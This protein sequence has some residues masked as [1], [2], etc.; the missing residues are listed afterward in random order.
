MKLLRYFLM[1]TCLLFSTSCIGKTAKASNNSVPN[2]N[3]KNKQKIN[4]MKKTLIIF[5]S[6]PGE[7]YGV[8]NIK[9]G[10][11]KI[12]ADDIMGMIEADEFEVVAK[13]SYDMP[14]EK[15]TEVAKEE[16]QKG[17]KPAFVGE[18][19]N[20]DQ[21]EVIFIGTP[22]WWGTFPQVMFTF[23]SK[24]DL[25]GKTIIPF[26][27]HEGS[28]LGSIVQDLKRLYPKANVTGAFSLFGHEV[29]TSK[30]KIAEWLQ[31]LGY[32]PKAE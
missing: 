32:T 29:R 2:N 22:I 3:L 18:L 6:H 13:K 4:T 28:G 10:N 25:N 11:T 14:Y 7:N 8:G 1:I 27:T 26:S 23:F 17:D 9:V 24:Y 30:G 21:Y 12:V 20:L 5:F 31:S 19:K 15:L 16:Q